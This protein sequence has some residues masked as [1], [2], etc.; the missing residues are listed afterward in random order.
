MAVVVVFCTAGMLWYAR[1]LNVIAGG[2]D[3]VART[4]GIH[5]ER[6]RLLVCAEAALATAAVISFTG[7]IG[8]VGLAG[9]IFDARS[10][11]D[12]ETDPGA[13]NDTGGHRD[14]LSGCADLH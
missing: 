4:L 14:L 10:G 9:G 7:V 12:R 8:F 6:I 13:G 5:P 3:E 2:D 11:Y 1:D